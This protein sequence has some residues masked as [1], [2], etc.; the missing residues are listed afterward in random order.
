MRKSGLIYPLL[1]LVCWTGF[2]IAGNYAVMETTLRQFLSRKF[3]VT[4]GKIV[5][6]EVA[7]G[8]MSHRG[9][10]IEY[11]YV[12][13]G[14]SYTG[15]RYRYDDRNAALKWKETVASYP[16]WSDCVVYYNPQHPGDSLLSPGIG[17]GDLLL[18]LFALPL[19]VGT[20]I[21][22]SM[23]RAR[24]RDNRPPSP[25][26]GVRILKQPGELRISLGETSA[27]EAGLFGLGMATFVLA[28]PV[29]IIG[30]FSPSLR[31]METVWAASVAFG[32]FAL[33]RRAVRNRSGIYDL[34]VNQASQT[35]TLPQT[36]GRKRTLSISQRAIGGVC[37]QRRSTNSPSGTHF[38][39]LP[40]LS[41]V[42]TAAEP[43]V[44][45]L[46]SWGWNEEKAR[47]FGQWLSGELGVEFKGIQE[48]KA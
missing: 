4:Q 21:L 18:L 3:P 44:M 28:F 8:S 43:P 10:E 5:L 47:A 22:W 9:V 12:V 34:R 33:L 27:L 42:V 45:P 15:N 31:L 11:N 30:G 16:R 17:G 1:L 13:N 36:T 37:L 41:P 6:S 48:E 20:Y 46:V 32:I 25:T 7:H 39:Y 38:S 26:G 24:W 40:A 19:D 29:V 23:A 35:V 2:V 14:I